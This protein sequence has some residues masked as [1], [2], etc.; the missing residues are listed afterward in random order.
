MCDKNSNFEK[1]AKEMNAKESDTTCSNLKF[2]VD[3]TLSKL[4][5]KFFW[6][7]VGFF[8]SNTT[9]QKELSKSSLNC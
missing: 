3:M 6:V 2:K 9:E 7:R 1:N 8:Y 5:T 4:K